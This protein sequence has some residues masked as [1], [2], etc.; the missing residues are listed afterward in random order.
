VTVFKYTPDGEIE[1]HKLGAIR[2]MCRPFLS[3][4][5]GLPELVKNS[6]AAYLRENRPERERVIIVTFSGKARGT[7][8]KIG[9]LDLVGMTSEQIERDF[10]N[11]GDPDA[12]TRS[13]GCDIRIGELGGHGNGGKCYITQMF[14]EYAFLHTAKD[15]RACKYGVRA[16]SVAFGYVPNMKAGRDFKV[17]DVAS[18]IEGALAEAGV[19]VSRLPDRARNAIHNAQGFTFV[20]G[21]KPKDWTG[22]RAAKNL[23]QNLI[24][25]HQMTTPLQLCSVYVIVDGTPHDEGK[26]L[27]LPSIEP[28][29]DHM[30]PRILTIPD[31]LRDPVSQEVVDTTND[32]GSAPGRLEIRTSEKNMRLGRGGR[33]QWRHTVDF[34]TTMS[35]VMGRISM[36]QL[37]VDSAYRDYLY[38]D[39]YLDSLDSCQQNERRELAESS[40]S[41]AVEN[42]ISGQ[43][44][45]YCRGLEATERQKIR[46]QDRDQ[47]S[48][49]NEWLDEWKNQFMNDLMR[50][51]YGEGEEDVTRRARL[52]PMGQAVSMRASMTNSLAGIGVY[53]RPKAEFFDA[54]GR[55]VRPMPYRWFSDDNNVALMDEDLMQIHTFCGGRAKLHAVTLDGR[56]KSNELPIEV[57]QIQR[58]R[59]APKEISVCVGSR[60]RLEAICTLAGGQETTGVNLTW[61]ED[62]SSVA[63]VS[64]SGMVYGAGAGQTKVTAVDESCR[65]DE[66]AKL[67]RSQLEVRWPLQAE[68]YALLIF[69]A[70]L[71]S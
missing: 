63:R 12:A 67:S 5:N 7:P 26:P 28:M 11:W 39:C 40:L 20:C 27:S 22:R 47:L 64:S 56:L 33:R 15:R 61:L 42:W 4:E 71:C 44:R 21:V 37:D 18:E 32:G 30:E 35:G 3:H 31:K 23:I 57:V 1:I 62:N 2:Q 24:V 25:H 49:M 9:C 65:S 36:L 58:I 69:L 6:A 46:A 51:L 13:S 14:E 55:R 10:R 54:Q 41:R 68:S 60:S 53:F 48:R 45:E 50:G 43:V 8:A 66:A 52:L 38:C 16:G 59:V 70:T 17:P 19:K 29:P 34:H